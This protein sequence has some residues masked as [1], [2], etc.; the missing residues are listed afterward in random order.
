MGKPADIWAAG[1]LLFALMHG[2]FPFRGSALT[3]T[4][5]KDDKE[6]FAAIRSGQFRVQ[7]SVSSSAQGLLSRMLAV[8]P[9]ERPTTAALLQD[10]WLSK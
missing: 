8:N 5:G 3:L 10:S 1:V 2:Y 9:A 7:S 4:T 6:L